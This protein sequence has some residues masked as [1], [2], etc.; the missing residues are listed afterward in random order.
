MSVRFIPGLRLGRMFYEEAGRQII[1]SVVPRE[2]YAAALMGYGSDVLGYDSERSTD[3]N[4]GPR[5]QVFLEPEVARQCAAG[6]DA[7]LRERLPREFHG[8]TACFSE[9]DPDDNGTQTPAP[10]ATGPV[11]HLVEIT[12]LADFQARY[13]GRDAGAGL[14]DLDWLVLPEQRLLEMTAGE[15]FHDPGGRLARLRQI[16]GWY[17]RDVWLY[18][19]ACQWHRIGQEEA[20]VGRC[21]EAGDRIGMRIVT[22][23]VLRDLMK[24]CFLMERTYA[25]YGKWLGTA[26]ARLACGPGLSPLIES[27][28]AEPEY[29]GIEA[30]LTA[31]YRSLGEMHNRLGVTGPVDPTPRRFFE[32]PYLVIGADRFANALL[33]AIR[34][35]ELRSLGLRI[36]AIDQFVD[37]TDYIENVGMYERTRGLFAPS[38]WARPAGP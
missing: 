25:P 12:T 32:R 35:E 5:F 8:Y 7:A 31:L 38:S 33:A 3:H 14:G 28:L 17:P 29:P 24:L 16:L 20:F 22:A 13:L 23:R 10:A 26:F 4:W 18:R 2:S 11:N 19:M 1:E 30:S 36:G 21:A 34:S 15:V 37:N 6:I 9:P 27:A